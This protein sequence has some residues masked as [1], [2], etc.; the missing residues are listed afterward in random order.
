MTRTWSAIE[1]YD[2][3]LTDEPVLPFDAKIGEYEVARDE[4]GYLFHSPVC[5][6]FIRYGY[7]QHMVEA[8][9][10]AEH[11]RTAFAH[12]VAS[13]AIFGVE[14]GDSLLVIADKITE[15]AFAQMGRDRAKKEWDRLRGRTSQEIE[16]D[17]RAALSRHSGERWHPKG[18]DTDA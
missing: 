4:M 2:K 1:T 11:P 13:L 12:A 16:D 10:L 3:L 7:C 5:S 14:E 6:D 9:A 15:V 17:A 8:R 18:I